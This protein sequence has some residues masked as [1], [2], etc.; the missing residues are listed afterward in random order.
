MRALPERLNQWLLTLRR[1]WSGPPSPIG[2]RPGHG[3]WDAPLRLFVGGRGVSARARR[4]A[5]Q[6]CR[7]VVVSAPVND[8]EVE[9]IVELAAAGV[10]LVADCGHLDPVGHPVLDEI[11]RELPSQSIERAR[12]SVCL[13]RRARPNP[14]GRITVVLATKRPT[15]LK[16]ALA[17]ID[18][19][20]DVEVDVVLGLHGAGWETQS[21]V[22]IAAMTD[23]PITLVRIP[24]SQSLGAV[25]NA[26]CREATAPII[27]KWDDDD[28]YGPMHL[29]DLADALAYS[30]ATIVGKAAEFVYLEASDL[31]IR[32][33]VRGGERFAQRLAG[34]TMT[35]RR[36]ELERLGWWPDV[37][38]HVD[39]CLL[40]QVAASGGS[41]YRTHG[42]GY[43]LMRRSGKHADHTWSATDEYFVSAAADRW[44]GLRIDEAT[45]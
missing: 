35:M 16:T 37:R 33:N 41:V 42:F 11:D 29:A 36:D 17:L 8:L 3:L 34:G 24:D 2:S 10:C 44:P 13:R 26:A 38:R 39:A 40:D 9:V 15:R 30:N 4:V 31:T 28:W 18:A 5:A 6:G 22:E 32:R 12:R 25:L 45:V 19:Q 27:S 7:S 20:Q 43:V 14:K 1:Q 21:D 23:S